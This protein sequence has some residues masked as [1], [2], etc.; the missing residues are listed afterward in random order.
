MTPAPTDSTPPQPPAPPR[1]SRA[2][3]VAAD[4]RARADSALT[5]IDAGASRISIQSDLF[6]L[7]DVDAGRAFE[8]SVT[9]THDF[10]A[11]LLD[12]RL[13]HLPYEAVT[14]WLFGTATRFNKFRAQRV[15]GAPETPYGLY[16]SS[17]REIFVN[18]A[19]AGITTLCHELT[20]PLLEAD[21]PR[22][23]VWFLEGMASLYELPDLISE[24]GQ[25]HGKPD[26]RRDD[27][28][29]A[30]SSGMGN[31]IRLETLF[32]MSDDKFRDALEGVHYAMAREAIR[33]LDSKEHKLWPFY[34]A[35][36]DNILDDRTGEKAFRRVVGKTPA[37]AS[38]AWLAWVTS[39][40]SAL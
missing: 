38:D 16:H 40:E 33:W 4:V 13:S 14:V 26:Q 23:P 18:T 39:P 25:V 30:L 10:L 37:E 34:T 17:T 8:P 21:A 5:L 31:T 9:L 22:A 7:V 12:G 3:R 29:R 20:H 1:P 24:P 32:A 6:V 11:V 19:S 35:W 27:L 2:D 36:R 15:P 28:L